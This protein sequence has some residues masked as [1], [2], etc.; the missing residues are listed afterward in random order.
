MKHDPRKMVAAYRSAYRSAPAA[1]ESA[2]AWAAPQWALRRAQAR[3]QLSS[4]GGRVTTPK[5]GRWTMEGFAPGAHSPDSA[6]NPDLSNIHELVS[7][8]VFSS[9]IAKSAINIIGTHGVGPGLEMR[10]AIDRAALGM[11]DDQA[12]QAEDHLKR[13]WRLWAHSPDASAS[14][15]ATF[16]DI[17]RLAYV[18]FRK[19]GDAFALLTAHQGRPPA[20]RPYSMAVQL[21]A[22]ERVSNSNMTQDGTLEN[23]GTLSAGIERGPGGEFRAIHVANKHPGD[24]TS[25]GATEWRTI[26]AFG[27]QSG[28]QNVLRLFRPE[29]VDQSRGLSDFAVVIETI[30][31]M[32]NYSDGE[33]AAALKAG[34][35]ALFV[36]TPEDSRF[37][38]ADATRPDSEKKG[39]DELQAGIFDLMPGE[40]ITSPVPGRPNDAFGPFMETLSQITGS[41]LK[42]PHEVLANRFG[43]S[44]SGSMA[45][46]NMF[47]RFVEDDRALLVRQLCQPTYEAWL[48]VAVAGGDVSAPGYFT[49]IAVR[50][51]WRGARWTGTPK[52]VIREDQAVNSANARI[53]GGLSSR[54]EEVTAL[55]GRDHDAVHRELVREEKMRQAGG[56]A[57]IDE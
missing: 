44:F 1:M 16:A 8:L 30:K 33:I 20:A 26:A 27:A 14:R 47:W 29:D 12:E 10:P 55:S 31:G 45:I 56:L 18:A 37:Q 46:V 52:P 54:Q 19:K 6:I 35:Y 15:D 5:R 28:R 39:P 32:S 40:K 48:D 36:E 51:A 21:I 4:Y 24:Y 38:V 34:Y 50:Q 17:Q 22:P 9:P 25:G 3:M 23:G 43:A 49:D 2:I 53:D 41:A 11:T 42:I 13:R 57:D 7:D